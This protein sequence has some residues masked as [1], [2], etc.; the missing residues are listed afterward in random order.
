MPPTLVAA[1]GRP[2]RIASRKTSPSPSQRDDI[3]NTSQAAIRSSTSSRTPAKIIASL[4]PS[5]AAELLEAVD[6]GVPAELS[7]PDQQEA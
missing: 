5:A 3:T 1:T 7:V 2:A 6:V 4:I